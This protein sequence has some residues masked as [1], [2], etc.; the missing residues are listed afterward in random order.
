M[1]Q[2][3]GKMMVHRSHTAM[4]SRT[5]LVGD[6]ILG[7]DRMLMMMRLATVVMMTRRGMMNP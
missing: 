3:A 1:N 7:L 4:A 2:G 5:V 6:A